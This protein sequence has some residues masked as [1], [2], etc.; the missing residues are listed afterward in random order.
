[1]FVGNLLKMHREMRMSIDSNKISFFAL[2]IKF[3]IDV[4]SGNIFKN[5]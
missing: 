2:F 3:L 5:K 4:F 1:M